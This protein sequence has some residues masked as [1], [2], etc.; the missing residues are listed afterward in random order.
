M[1]PLAQA[2]AAEGTRNYLTASVAWHQDIGVLT[3][4]ADAATILSCWMAITDA[5]VEN[6]CLKVFPG[7]HRKDLVDHCPT[8]AGIGIPDRL[9]TLRGRDAIADARRVGADLRPESDPR[10]DRQLDRQPG[11]ISGRSLVTSRPRSADG[12]PDFPS[13]T[14]RS[15]SDPGRSVLVDPET[16]RR[17]WAETRSCLAERELGKFNCCDAD[18]PVCA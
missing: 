4:E 16:W 9:L 7:S 15:A 11:R 13:S 1:K 10:R 8:T 18:S 17:I 12:R 2:L 5:T 14:A 3:E 6:G